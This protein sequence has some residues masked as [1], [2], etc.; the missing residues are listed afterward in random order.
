MNTLQRVLTLPR[1]RGSVNFLD[2]V[3]QIHLRMTAAGL[4][5]G[6]IATGNFK[7]G[8]VIRVDIAGHIATIKD[9]A[10]K[11]SQRGV[12]LPDRLLGYIS[13]RET[14]RRISGN[15]NQIR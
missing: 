2:I 9:R 4:L 8:Q 15:T 3:V 5:F 12:D 13:P 14:P 10:I 11:F 7:A 6:S 1:A